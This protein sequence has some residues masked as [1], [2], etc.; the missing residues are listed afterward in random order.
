[1]LI[2]QAIDLAEVLGIVVEA[3]AVRRDIVMRD[4]GKF[5]DVRRGAFFSILCSQ[6][7]RPSRKLHVAAFGSGSI[8]FAHHRL[9][10]VWFQ[11]SWVD[12]LYEL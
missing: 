4:Q 12:I 7:S 1:M 5:G 11:G 10:L 3:V 6:R 2:A 9:G 8:C